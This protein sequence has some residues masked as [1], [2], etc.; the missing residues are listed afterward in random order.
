MVSSRGIKQKIE[1][2]IYA[3]DETALYKNSIKDISIPSPTDSSY[4]LKY[5]SMVLLSI[6]NGCI[7]N[8]GLIL[9]LRLD[10]RL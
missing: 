3:L 5:N 10:L 7:R 6:S 9:K 4:E 1:D 8:S 2:F